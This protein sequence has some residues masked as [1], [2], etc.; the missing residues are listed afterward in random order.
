M[1]ESCVAAAEFFEEIAYSGFETRGFRIR[2]V[3]S[4]S[5]NQSQPWRIILI[6]VAHVNVALGNELL[7]GANDFGAILGRGEV[8]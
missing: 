8:V 3:R 5:V 1:E 2:E 4:P 7:D 6:G